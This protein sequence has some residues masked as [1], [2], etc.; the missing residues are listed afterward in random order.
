MPRTESTS[1]RRRARRV[2]ALCRVQT[3]THSHSGNRGLQ[4]ALPSSTNIFPFFARSKH[5]WCR[6]TRVTTHPLVYR[7]SCARVAPPFDVEAS[8]LVHPI[9]VIQLASFCIQIAASACIS[10]QGVGEV[11]R[12]I[13]NSERKE[14][15]M[16]DRRRTAWVHVVPAVMVLAA[17]ATAAASAQAAPRAAARLSV[18]TA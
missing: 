18:R 13:R 17:V 15:G 3:P 2:V 1:S 8:N 4:T 5:I 7:T 9:V 14:D 16:N 6:S 12:R 10:W 11:R